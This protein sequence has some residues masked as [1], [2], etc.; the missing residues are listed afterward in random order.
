MSGKEQLL[1]KIESAERVIPERILPDLP[2][3][4]DFPDVPEWH[5]FEH[6][7]WSA[8]EQ[9]RDIFKNHPKLKKAPEIQERILKICFRRQAKRGR[10]S[11]VLLLGSPYFSNHSDKISSLLEDDD[12]CGHVIDALL[13]MKASNYLKQI[14]PLTSHKVIWMRNQA[15]KY[16]KKFKSL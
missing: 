6:S 11:F 5:S 16:V 15:K 1:L 4:K 9:I 8:G 3:Q 7:V 2:G 13:K 14:E 10:Q 12:V